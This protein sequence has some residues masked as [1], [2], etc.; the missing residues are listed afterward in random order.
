MLPN[1]VCPQTC[2]PALSHNL[3]YHPKSH[4][5]QQVKLHETCFGLSTLCHL[6]SLCF[7]CH[8]TLHNVTPSPLLISHP[9][10]WVLPCLLCLLPTMTFGHRLMFCTQYLEQ[11]WLLRNVR[12]RGNKKCAMDLCVHVCT[13]VCWFA[14]YFCYKHF[15]ATFLYNLFTKIY[16]FP[17][18]CP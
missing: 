10:T 1:S 18:C 4:W 16:T 3:I 14:F 12:C 6:L 17:F 7:S 5:L 11:G 2:L 9:V 13:C 8:L 15:Y